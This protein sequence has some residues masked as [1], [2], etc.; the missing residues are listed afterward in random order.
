M[1]RVNGPIT[2]NINSGGPPPEKPPGEGTPPGP[3]GPGGPGMGGPGMGMGPQ[4]PA[5]NPQ[6]MMEVYNAYFQALVTAVSEKKSII[7][8]IY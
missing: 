4:M 1:G 8:G 3:Q 6:A 5:I 7:N 2:L